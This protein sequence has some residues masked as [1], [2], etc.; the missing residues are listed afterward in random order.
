MIV[1]SLSLSYFPELW[2]GTATQ[3]AQMTNMT[4]DSGY[5]SRGFGQFVLARESALQAARA[6]TEQMQDGTS[7]FCRRFLLLPT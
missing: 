2:S 1:R 6:R 3:V 7:M 4:D 5:S